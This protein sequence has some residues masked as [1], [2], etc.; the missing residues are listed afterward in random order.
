M[1]ITKV[2]GMRANSSSGCKTQRWLICSKT[3]ICTC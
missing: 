2:R 3:V 1:F